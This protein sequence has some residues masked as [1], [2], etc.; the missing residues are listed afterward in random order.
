MLAEKLTGTHPM[1]MLDAVNIQ[2]HEPTPPTPPKIN[3]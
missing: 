1:V 2:R 3:T